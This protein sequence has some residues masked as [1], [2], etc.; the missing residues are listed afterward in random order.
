MRLVHD[1]QIPAD[2]PEPRQDFVPFGQIEGGDDLLLLQPLVDAELI[3]DVAPFENEKLLVKF[4]LEL[5]L[6]L[7]GQVGRAND[8]DL[9]G[10]PTQ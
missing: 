8:H 3:A 6:P 10:K 1:H 4:L 7:E 2:L 5:P 9:L